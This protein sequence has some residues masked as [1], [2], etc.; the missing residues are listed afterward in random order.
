MS[1]D[2]NYY[3]P[4]PPDDP[5]WAQ[6]LSFFA[7]HTLAIATQPVCAIFFTLAIGAMF[8]AWFS[9]G[10]ITFIVPALLLGWIFAAIGW[11]WAPN[12]STAA[13]VIWIVIS[14]APFIGETLFLHWH[15]HGGSAE[16]PMNASSGSSSLKDAEKEGSLY[17]ECRAASKVV[18]FS[19]DGRITLLA[20]WFLPVENG[21]GGFMET[22]GA[23]GSK[24]TFA[25]NPLFAHRCQI[26]NY[27][28]GPVFS[29][30]LTFSIRYTE[31]IK[32]P[33]GHWQSGKT[34]LD[35]PW[36][37][38]IGKIDSGIQTPFVFF[39]AP[40]VP[41][42]SLFITFPTE[43]FAL[44]L[45]EQNPRSIKLIGGGGILSVMPGP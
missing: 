16:Q 7:R 31:I 42:K 27:E 40:G 44:R 28:S 8:A 43:G 4:E 17:V 25:N 6:I 39:V 26:T 23:P 2:G 14:G 10:E 3:F 36:R 29:V 33:E 34:L 32:Q 11:W 5:L 20:P 38:R 24:Y 13:R 1:D 18:N 45:G 9:N 15:Y 21:G 12:L 35:R 19:S 37:V 22:S 41:D 30:D